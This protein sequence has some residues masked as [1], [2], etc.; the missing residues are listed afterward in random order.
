MIGNIYIPITVGLLQDG[1]LPFYLF[2]GIGFG[3]Q[4][5]LLGFS[6]FHI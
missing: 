5:I 3:A 6:H 2:V 1:N 4:F